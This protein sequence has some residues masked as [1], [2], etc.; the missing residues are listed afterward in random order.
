MIGGIA[1][2]ALISFF[3][4]A[5]LGLSPAAAENVDLTPEQARAVARDQ[6]QKGNFQLA[7]VISKALVKRDGND[8]VALIILASTQISAG[9]LAD[10]VQTGKQAFRVARSDGQRAEAARLVASAHYRAKQFTRAE[11][12]LRR[13]ANNAPQGPMHTAIRQDFAKVRQEN[14]LSVSLSFSAAPNNNVNNGSSSETITIW[15]LPFVLSADAQALAGY[16]ASARADLKYRI[17]QSKNHATHL[18]LLLSARSY[19][20]SAA[21]KKAAPTVKGSDYSFGVAEVSLS[22]RQKFAAMSGPTTF[23]LS[24]GQNWYGGDPYTRYNRVRLGQ[25]FRLTERT[26]IDLSLGYE[27]QKVIASAVPSYISTGTVAIN[28]RLGNSDQ[29]G[30]SLMGQK[31]ASPI[32]SNENTVIHAQLSYSLGKPVWGMR[33]SFNLGGQKRDYDFSNYDASGRH[34]R[35]LTL[36]ATAVFEKVSYFGFSPSMTLSTSKTESNVDLFDRETASLNFGLQSN[37]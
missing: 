23:A 26:T 35:T 30:F 1:R 27:D 9:Q 24:V 37:F 18:G 5:L 13:A 20:L 22:H 17:S 8:F 21:S 25:N 12:W 4:A 28:H 11:F 29:I 6:L 3:F 36:G 19:E 32:A 10:A 33:L 16:E 2:N 15:G 7:G 14:P 31:T 34:D